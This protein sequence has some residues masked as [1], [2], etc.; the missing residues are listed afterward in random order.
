MRKKLLSLALLLAMPS[1]VMAEEFYLCHDGDGTLPQSGI[2]AYVYDEADY[3]L[4]TNWAASDADD[5]KIGWTDTVLLLD[6]GGDFTITL[7]T[8][9]AGNKFT[10][11]AA[12]GETP[13]LNVASGNALQ[14]G[15]SGKSD[16]TIGPGIEFAGWQDA[17][18]AIRIIDP[19]SGI[20]ITGNLFT[21][22]NAAVETYAINFYIANAATGGVNGVEVDLNDFQTNG[23]VEAI[24][25]GVYTTTALNRIGNLNHHHNNFE[26]VKNGLRFYLGAANQDYVLSNGLIPFNVK[27]DDN[28]G[29]HSQAA[30]VGTQAGISEVDGTSSFSRNNF[31]YCGD[32]AQD[33]VN[34]LQMFYTVGADINDNRLRYQDTATCD[35]RFIILDWAAVSDLYL[36]S[37]NNVKR[38]IMEGANAACGGGCISAYKATDNDIEHNVCLGATGSAYKVGSNESTGNSFTG[39]TA[40][41]VLNCFAQEDGDNIGNTATWINNLCDSPTG[42]GF[43]TVNNS[44]AT[45][46]YNLVYNAPANDIALDATD[47]TT[48]P[49][50]DSAGRPRLKS[51]YDAGAAHD[52][53]YCGSAEPIG[54]YE[55]CKGVSMPPPLWFLGTPDSYSL[56]GGRVHV[57]YL[58]VGDEIVYLGVA[59]IE[60]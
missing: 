49:Q 13:V 42:K 18:A 41:A 47:I 6:D 40:A 9:L 36:S 10:I 38:N 21:K 15:N 19:L 53:I 16:L 12:I 34:C 7:A 30:L 52:N 22:A 8:P 32:A 26:S 24:R 4:S 1:V 3:N 50:L 14:Y 31:D 51:L 48:D 2:C 11:K 55:L 28:T 44:I 27:F 37:A 20:R 45:E 23:K 35:G 58:Y 25:Y 17:N 57:E 46:S 43:K 29:N 59:P 5:G 33:A 54:A 60:M 39:N 56:G